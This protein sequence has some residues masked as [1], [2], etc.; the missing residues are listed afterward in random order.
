MYGES[1]QATLI[2]LSA[3]YRHP[4]TGETGVYVAPD[5]GAETDPVE[6]IDSTNPPPLSQP[7]M[8]EFVGIDVIA[9]GRETAGVVGVQGGDWIVSVGQN[10]LINN[11]SG[12][13]KIRATS[14][15]RIMRM[16]QMKPQDL[17]R[18]IMNERMAERA[19]NNESTES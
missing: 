7:T 2:P 18:D 6:Q 9:Q 12:A 10:L 8:V 14:W 15:N 16:Q 19:A 11:E 17:L 4:R 5:F 1:E 13:A 3:I